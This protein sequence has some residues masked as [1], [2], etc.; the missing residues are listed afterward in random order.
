MPTFCLLRKIV[1]VCGNCLFN[2]DALLLTI[3][4]G[5]NNRL[6]SVR[7]SNFL[8]TWVERKLAMM[9]EIKEEIHKKP[10]VEILLYKAMIRSGNS[11]D[12]VKIISDYVCIKL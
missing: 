1:N 2:C 8:C 3:R 7:Y 6:E 12:L 5:C 10:R 9:E 4:I 11:I